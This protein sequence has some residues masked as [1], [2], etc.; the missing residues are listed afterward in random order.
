M[1]AVP[2]YAKNLSNSQVRS[3]DN[4]TLNKNLTRD[5]LIDALQALMASQR[6]LPPVNSDLRHLNV[7]E[8]FVSLSPDLSPCFAT[9]S[10]F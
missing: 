7:P 6:I 10:S 9:V 8:S 4:E 5:Q 1:T 2:E 3:L